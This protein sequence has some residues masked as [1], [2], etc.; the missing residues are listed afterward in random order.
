M[1]YKLSNTH[2]PS[3]KYSLSVVLNFFEYL[4]NS[5]LRCSTACLPDDPG[6]KPTTSLTASK[7]FLMALAIS[8]IE[9]KRFSIKSEFV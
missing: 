4:T 3:L 9:N 6:M 5:F 7:S 2:C 1:N 8:L